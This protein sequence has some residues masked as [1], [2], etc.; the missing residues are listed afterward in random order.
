M[1]AKEQF[2]K[3]IKTF[4]KNPGEYTKEEIFE[5]CYL[6]RELKSGKSWKELIEIL[7]L[8]DEYP[9]S[10][11]RKTLNE[12]KKK[13]PI[14]RPEEI[15]RRFNTFIGD[16]TNIKD[17]DQQF[18][19]LYKEKTKVRDIWNAYR[20][21]LREDARTES[22]QD[23]IVEAVSE[24]EPLINPNIKFEEDSFNEDVEAILLL[25]DWHI[26][27]NNHNFY[28][29]FDSGIAISR[30]KKVVN[31][32]IKYC[33]LNKVKKLNV[34]NLGD[35]VEGIINPNA[36]IEEEMSV[37]KQ[38]IFATELMAEALNQLQ[39]AAPVVT[40]RD[41]T[42]NHS[43]AI[44]DKHQSIEEENFNLLTTWFLKERLKNSKIHFMDDN[45]SVD[46]GKFYASGKCVMFMHGHNDAKDKT[47]QS[48][49]GA[50]KEWVDIVCCGHWHNPA[51]HT[52]QDMKLFVNGSLCGT[53][54][55][56]LKRRLFCKPSQKLLILDNNII[57]IDIQLK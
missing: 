47:L 21:G 52:Y 43:R 48:M 55:Y 28:N 4:N 14:V 33:K 8:N 10:L 6:H 36:R 17:L 38:L 32:T 11:R 42:D 25:S 44:S 15:E 30:V 1:I 49:I 16:E 45:L 12:I 18:E 24:I 37:T 26:G 57:D 56:A 29:D 46:L 7:G 51:E 9:D 22:W 19:E 53:G 50:T 40:Y 35:L 13:N 20:R 31:D 2:L 27:E 34:L 54:S 5:I 3:Y 41:V 23:R 39:E